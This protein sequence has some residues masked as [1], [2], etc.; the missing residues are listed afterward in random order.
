MSRVPRPGWRSGSIGAC[1]LL[2]GASLPHF[3]LVVSPHASERSNS[4]SNSWGDT[5]YYIYMNEW[6]ALKG[7]VKAWKLTFSLVP[8]SSSKLIFWGY[9]E[10]WRMKVLNYVMFPS[11]LFLILSM[12]L[13]LE[14]GIKSSIASSLWFVFRLILHPLQRSVL[15][16]PWI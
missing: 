5:A 3:L 14:L 16:F 15:P 6:Y 12:I 11:L 4:R 8:R 7:T 10:F 1:Q 9:A 2:A 13:Y